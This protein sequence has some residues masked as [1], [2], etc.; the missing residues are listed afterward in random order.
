MM[1]TSSS[2]TSPSVS[3]EYV[4]AWLEFLPPNSIRSWAKLKQAFIGNFQGTYVH[5]GNTWDLKS[6]KQKPSESL[7]DYIHRFSKKCNSLPDVINIDVIST[8]LSGTTYKSLVHKLGCRKP[9]T[10]LELLD[11]ATNHASGE[12]VVRAVFTNGRAKG[13]AK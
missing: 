3:G 12:E 11:I 2:N 7:R 5:P 6:C 8:F 4:R 10:T 13:K 1:I 9:R